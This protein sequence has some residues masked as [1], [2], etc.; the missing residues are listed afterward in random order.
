MISLKKKVIEEKKM[1][2]LY[3]KTLGV[4]GTKIKQLTDSFNLKQF[5]G[6]V[7]INAVTAECS[8]LTINKVF[9]KQRIDEIYM[10][11]AIVL[12]QNLDALLSHLNKK[13][14]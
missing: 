9:E 3:L 12:Q 10:L 14:N 8:I 4:E 11:L 2:S 1:I 7:T 5:I 13:N 6:P